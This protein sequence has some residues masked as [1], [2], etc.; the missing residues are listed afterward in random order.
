[1]LCSGFMD[2]QAAA[3]SDPEVARRTMDINLTASVLVL[4]PF[5]AHL[6]SKGSGFIAGVSSVAGDR[7]RMSNYLYGASK[8]G[9]TAYL[10][11]LRNRLYH[12]GVSVTTI[13]PGFIDTKMTW[14]LP[15]LFLVAHP[16]SAALAM[17]EA[18]ERKKSVVYVPWFWRYI[19]LIIRSIPEWQFRRMKL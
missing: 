4:E 7:G 11:G 18:I 12:A 1:M 2:E 16:R 19:M 8:A 9:F 13:K 5:A 10:S 6:E 3:Q 15:G 17:V 14:G